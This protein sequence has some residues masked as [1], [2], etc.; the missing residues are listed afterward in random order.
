MPR[1]SDAQERARELDARFGTMAAADLV[2]VAAEVVFPGRLALMT[3]FG[4]ESAVLLDLVA[5]VDRALPVLFADTRR[6]FPQTLAYR[7]A[8]V[9]HLGLTEVRTVSPTAA[10]E[11][12]EDPL[13]AL[14]AVDPDRCCDLRKVRPMAAATKPFDAWITGR[15]RFQGATRAALA[16]F[17]A[18]GSHIRVNPLAAWTSSDVLAY[19]AT[20]G[21]PRHTLVAQGYRSIGCQPCTTPVAEGEDERAGRWRGTAKTECGLH[22]APLGSRA[23]GA[24]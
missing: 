20:A 7:D 3:S 6:L 11:A 2:A 10:D 1:P 12:A 16:A 8:L 21:L 22:V 24:L 23:S 9:D 15:K 14:F 5:K 19:L 17:D 18:E 4:A 13:G